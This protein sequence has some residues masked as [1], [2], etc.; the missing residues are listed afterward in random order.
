[1]G[2]PVMEAG[3]LAEACIEAANRGSQSWHTPLPPNSGDLLLE[4]ERTDEYCARGSEETTRVD[5][6]TSLVL[7]HANLERR[8]M[9][10][11]YR[12]FCM[13]LGRLLER[14]DEGD[15]AASC[16]HFCVQ[17]DPDDTTVARDDDIV[18]V[19]LMKRENAWFERNG[20]ET[21]RLEQRMARSPATMHSSGRNP[22][23]PPELR[24]GRLPFADP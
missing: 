1:M 19:E 11:M 24:T 20:Q 21:R 16:A 2:A 17:G 14:E 23:G 15:E 22:R 13:R 8:A 12:A 10:Q 6:W 7:E 5:R 4:R 18:A 9:E 3:A